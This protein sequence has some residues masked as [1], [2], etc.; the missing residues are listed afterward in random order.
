MSTCSN[1]ALRFSA[2]GVIGISIERVAM[3]RRKG[4]TFINDFSGK[5]RS[6]VAPMSAP[7][8]EKR[9]KNL[10]SL[11]NL[12][13][14]SLWGIRAKEFA[15]DTPREFVIEAVIGG[16]PKATKMGK[17]IAEAP[18]AREFIPPTRTPANKT[19]SALNTKCLSNTRAEG[20]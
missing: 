11:Q 16:T 1:L 17:E 13:I 18:A 5:V 14:F 2:V 15:V 7:I 6:R 19:N 20:S 10:Y 9:A 8:A 12:P 3:R 4:T